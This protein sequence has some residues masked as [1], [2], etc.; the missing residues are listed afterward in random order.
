MY[1]NKVQDVLLD[2]EGVSRDLFQHLSTPV[3]TTL[4]PWPACVSQPAPTP[5]LHVCVLSEPKAPP[6]N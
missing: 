5:D 6:A 2:W 1:H 4:V 3:T